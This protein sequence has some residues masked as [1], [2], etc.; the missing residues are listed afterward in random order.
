MSKK[1]NLKFST[2]KNGWVI[3]TFPDNG[4]LRE[5]SV[6]CLLLYAILQRL[7]EPQP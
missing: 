1:L 7:E 3:V 2:D 4:T 5:Q 6:E